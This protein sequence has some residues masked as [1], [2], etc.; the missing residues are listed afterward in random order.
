VGY[1]RARYISFPGIA[2]YAGQT[3]VGGCDLLTATQDLSGGRKYRSPDWTGLLGVNYEWPLS[4]KF[5][6]S[7]DTGMRFSSKYFTQEN[8]SVA[9]VQR[10]YQIYDASVRLRMDE[11]RWEFALI[12]KNL[13]DK[14]YAISSLD[15]PNGNPG[16]IQS[17]VNRPREV[18]V[19]GM[20]RF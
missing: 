15:L 2:C 4:D 12:G 6:A 3:A 1:A 18:I 5:V 13:S 9:A 19:E 14:R 17:V 10:A 11:G 8:N 7:F 16:D 20:F